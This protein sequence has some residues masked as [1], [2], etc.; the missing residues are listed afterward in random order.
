MQ[1]VIQSNPAVDFVEG[2]GIYESGERF[3]L[4]FETVRYGTMYK[5][6]QAG[7]I[8]GHAVQ[9]GEDPDVAVAECLQKMKDFPDM[10]NTLA[11]A[12]GLGACVTAEAQEKRIVPVQNWGDIIELD[13]K[14]YM[15]LMAANQNVNVVAVL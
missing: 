6:F 10:G 11:W 7:T 3:A 14:R 9:E 1:K 8:A 13:G 4:P 12:F 15:L 5:T 2:N